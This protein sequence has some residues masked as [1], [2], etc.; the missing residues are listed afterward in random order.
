MQEHLKEMLEEVNSGKA[1]LFDVREI[2]EWEEG[3]LTLAKWVPLSTLRN[4]ELPEGMEFDKS[5]KTYL[6]CR[7]GQRVQMAAPILEEIGFDDVIPLSEG[8]DELVDE[9]LQEAE[10]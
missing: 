10:S 4:Y 6:H 5:V 3:H 7:S 8:F 1:V 2:D 9:G